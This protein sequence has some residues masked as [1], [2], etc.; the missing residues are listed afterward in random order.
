MVLDRK[1]RKE[2]KFL[3]KYLFWIEKK[4]EGR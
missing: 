2:M 1:R 4:R 3:G